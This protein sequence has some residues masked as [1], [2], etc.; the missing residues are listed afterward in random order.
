MLKVPG[1]QGL[2]LLQSTNYKGIFR[3]INGHDIQHLEDT[4]FKLDDSNSVYTLI[5]R[6]EVATKDDLLD[7]DLAEFN[8]VLKEVCK[9]LIEKK[10]LTPECWL[11]LVFIANG[12]RFDP[13]YSPWL[14]ISITQLLGMSEIAKKY[15]QSF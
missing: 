13:D 3:E 12:K 14:D 15:L 11:E 1:K 8:K 6:L 2:W 4:R 7:L 10:I 5:K 9:T